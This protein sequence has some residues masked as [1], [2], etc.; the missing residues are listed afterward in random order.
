MRVAAPG[1][2]STSASTVNGSQTRA[3]AAVLAREQFDQMV[4]DRGQGLSVGWDAPLC[5]QLPGATVCQRTDLIATAS[6]N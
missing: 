1:S 2:Y 4:L 3:D 6:Y 5:A